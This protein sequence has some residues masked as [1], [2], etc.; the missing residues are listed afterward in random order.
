MNINNV[1]ITA[2]AGETVIH[3]FESVSL[4]ASYTAGM[5]AR[6]KPDNVLV[7][8]FTLSETG[9]VFTAT[10]QNT[11]NQG[12]YIYDLIVKNNTTGTFETKFRGTIEVL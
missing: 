7:S 11:F 9:G 5:Q 10:S 2:N 4:P 12:I 6:R 1:S 8:D 3:E